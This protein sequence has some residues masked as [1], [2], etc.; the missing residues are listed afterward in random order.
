M[1]SG[2][3]QTLRGNTALV[4][5]DSRKS[6]FFAGSLDGSD[7]RRNHAIREAPQE[8]STPPSHHERPAVGKVLA[9]AHVFIPAEPALTAEWLHSQ[10]DRRAARATPASQCP[11]DVPGIS[12][13]V[14][15]GGP[16]FWVT[17]AGNDRKSAEE[18]LRRAQRVVR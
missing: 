17:I 2:W 13:S 5:R 3:R 15:S 4:T 12:I 16:G 7:L 9:G 10:L 1:P 18:V 11:L 14:K 6:G 8:T